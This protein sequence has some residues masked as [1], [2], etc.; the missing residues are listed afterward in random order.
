MEFRNHPAGTSLLWYIACVNVLVFG[1]MSLGFGALS[2]NARQAAEWGAVFRPLVLEGEWWRL[3]AGNYI[4]FD[5]KHIL[6]NMLALF[7][8]GSQVTLRFGRVR[9]GALYTLSG[10]AASLASLATH[11]KTVCAGAS[12]PISGILGALFALYFAGDKSLS[13]SGLMQALATSVVYSL[14]MPS[15]DWQAHAGGFVAGWILAFALL[16]TFPKRYETTVESSAVDSAD[17]GERTS[18]EGG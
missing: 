15:I 6:F 8:W 17:R 9:F 2:F 3:L 11:P 7:A 1:A 16:R 5:L 10:L 18:S 13:G 14:L 4:H 12:G